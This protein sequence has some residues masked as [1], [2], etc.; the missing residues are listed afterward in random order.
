MSEIKQICKIMIR[1]TFSVLSQF[2]VLHTG[3]T[4]H[5]LRHKIADKMMN[6]DNKKRKVK[7][8]SYQIDKH[9]YLSN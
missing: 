1:N 2:A 5:I 9:N 4:I 3:K 7:F 6:S 8:A